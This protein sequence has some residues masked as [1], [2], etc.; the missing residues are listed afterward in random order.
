MLLDTWE[1]VHFEVMET[2]EGPDNRV[3]AV[4]HWSVRGREGIKLEMETMDVFTF[5]G[6]LVLRIDGFLE[7]A[8]AL[9]AAGLS[10]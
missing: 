10:E 2:L 4:D 8:Q 9:E 6:G 1:A 3:F 7:R 5:R